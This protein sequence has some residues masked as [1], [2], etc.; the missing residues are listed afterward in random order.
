MTAL[1]L[2]A[3]AAQANN[4]QGFGRCKQGFA[5]GTVVRT[6]SRGNLTIGEVRVSDRVWSFNEMV[7]K[8]GW[9]K[10][11]QRVDGK[12]HYKLLSDFSEPGSAA[13][14]KACWNIKRAS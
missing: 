12:Q 4:G 2:L 10:V 11:L 7:G 13:V 1:Y 14:T 6:E 5:D 9:S 8:P 3:S